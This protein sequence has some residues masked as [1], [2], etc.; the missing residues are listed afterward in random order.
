MSIT[1]H[2]VQ[3]IE[4]IVTGEKQHFVEDLLK[5]CGTTGYTI[6][7]DISG[8]GEHGYHEGRLMF[9]DQDSLIMFV[10]VADEDVIHSIA[11]GLLPLFREQSGVMFVT[12]TRV[13]RP[14]KFS[15]ETS[16]A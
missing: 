10:V 13:A 11:E 6:I 8:L 9:N 15:N 5:Q 3:K 7:H 1:F 14:E 16:G 12:N 2:S 4:I